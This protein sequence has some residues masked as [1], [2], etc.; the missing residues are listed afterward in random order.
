MVRVQYTCIQLLREVQNS[1]GTIQVLRQ[2]N[3]GW[4]VSEIWY[5]LLIYCT[6]HSDVGGRVSLNKKSQS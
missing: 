5:F 2:Q 1:F 3:G 4:V 6:I